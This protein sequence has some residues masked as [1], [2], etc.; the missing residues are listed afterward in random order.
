MKDMSMDIVEKTIA[1]LSKTIETD[2]INNIR[3]IALVT[4]SGYEVVCYVDYTDMP[5]DAEALAEE[6]IISFDTLENY[7][8]SVAQTVRKSKLFQHDKTN[9]VTY[10]PEKGVDFQY[11]ASDCVDSLFIESWIKSI[12]ASV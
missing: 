4:V 11:E 10:D 1:N 9:I 3:C 12:E 5:T 7:Y 6:D 8:R 2:E